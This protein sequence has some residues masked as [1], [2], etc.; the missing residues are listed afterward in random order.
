MDQRATGG[1][2]FPSAARAR[3]KLLLAGG[4]LAEGVRPADTREDRLLE[5]A[6]RYHF[7]GKV[8]GYTKQ[9]T[10]SLPAW[11]AERMPVIAELEAEVEREAREREQRKQDM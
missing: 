8:Y 4:I 10:D 1:R 2:Q 9:E 3:L 5:K 6:A 7:F 11:L